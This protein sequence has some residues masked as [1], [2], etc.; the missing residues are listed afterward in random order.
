MVAPMELTNFFHALGDESRLRILMVIR[1]M[2]LTVG[3]IAQALG[4][5]QPRIS[6]HVRILAE[7][8]IARRR[9]E[10][11]WTFVEPALPVDS[12]LFE[13]IDSRMEGAI[14][15][16]CDGDAQRLDAIRIERA[17]TASQWFASRA[18]RWDE[19]RSLHIEEEQV[20][21]AT[22][23]ALEGRPLG[24]LVDVGTGTG[25]MLELFAPGASEAIGIDR[26]PDMLRLARVRL[27]A[28]GDIAA[29]LRQGDMFALPLADGAADTVILHQVLHFAHQPRAAIDEAA[30]ILAPGG[31]LVLVD[32]AAHD[33]EDLRR[34]HGHQRLGFTDAAIA[35]MVKLAGLKPARPVRLDGG[36]LTVTIW[37]AD[38]PGKARKVAA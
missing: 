8:G 19:L 15:E 20:E 34:Q 36:E 16:A 24:R 11:S 12:P 18:E 1:S 3:E 35:D 4:Q 7:A 6:R 32:F 9:K 5:S 23:K 31:R 17:E 21:A 27:E 14:A 13:I 2:E 26:S 38:R 30:R 22:A 25:R 10:G 28:A 37:A 29:S 33:R